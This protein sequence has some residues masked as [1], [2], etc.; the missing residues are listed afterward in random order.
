MAVLTNYRNSHGHEGC[1][2]QDANRNYY[3]VRVPDRGKSIHK[4]YLDYSADTAG[5]NRQKYSGW[6]LGKAHEV[7]ESGR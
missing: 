4:S 5:R 3:P 6:V 1:R 2:L 7:Q